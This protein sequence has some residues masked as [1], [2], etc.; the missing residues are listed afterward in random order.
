VRSTT[1]AEA[2]RGAVGVPQPG[3]GAA[4][5]ADRQ[6]RRQRGCRATVK[7]VV[8]TT[9]RQGPSI[10]PVLRGTFH[11]DLHDPPVGRSTNEAKLVA[12]SQVEHRHVG[13]QGG[14]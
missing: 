1:H 2:D 11:D 4:T 5:L 3:T 13:G 14:R 10:Q 12:A 8:E 7:I 6:R 9:C